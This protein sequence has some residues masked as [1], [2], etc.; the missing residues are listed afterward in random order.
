MRLFSRG[1]SG[2]SEPPILVIHVMKTGGTTIMR[3]LRETYDLEQI[4]PYAPVDLR[5][6]DGELDIGHHLSVPYLRSLPPER[7]T[8]IRVYIGHFPYVVRELLGFETRA[9]TV[10]RDPV[11]RTISMLRQIKRKQPWEDDPGERRPL[12]ARSLAEV[13]EHPFVFEPLV[14]N[15]QTKIFSMAPAD[16]PHTYMDVIDVDGDRL[17]RAKAHLAEVEVLGLQERYDEFLDEAEAVFGWT[18]VRGARKNATPAESATPVDPALRRRIEADNALD[19]ELYAHAVELVEARRRA[20]R[21]PHR[22]PHRGAR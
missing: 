21:T 9:A 14:H 3:N 6:V 18:I 20:G 17:A 22:T 4:Y 7:R 8:A 1:S 12:A 11:E 13:Y 10:L 5:H 16:D 2:S 19:L 15:H